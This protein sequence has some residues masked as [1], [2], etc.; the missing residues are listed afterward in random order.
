MADSDTVFLQ[1]NW[2]IFFFFFSLSNKQERMKVYINKITAKSTVQT[3][4]LLN[5]HSAFVFVFK[6]GVKKKGLPV[7]LNKTKVGYI[8]KLFQNV[9]SNNV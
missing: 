6:F 9:K 2:P 1:A 5:Q 7:K 8:N 4:M 3:K